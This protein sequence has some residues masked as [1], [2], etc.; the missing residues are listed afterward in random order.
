MAYVRSNNRGEKY[1]LAVQWAPQA[2]PFIL[3]GLS[4]LPVGGFTAEVPD[5]TPRQLSDLV[6]RGDLRYALLDAPGAPGLSSS[7]YP[8]YAAWVRQN[9]LPVDG[10]QHTLYDCRP[11]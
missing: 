9:C 8:D 7:D 1:V 3:A 10:F 6:A 4:A 11:S 2:G 5:V